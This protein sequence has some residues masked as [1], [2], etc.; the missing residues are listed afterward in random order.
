MAARS[1]VLLCPW[2]EMVQDQ[3]FPSSYSDH[4]RHAHHHSLVLSL[5]TSEMSR[6]WTC[7]HKEKNNGWITNRLLAFTE[8]DGNASNKP[9]E[10]HLTVSVNLI[11]DY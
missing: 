6:N 4:A 10:K 5:A 8:A 9:N 1:F 3:Q 11:I 2:F 7:D